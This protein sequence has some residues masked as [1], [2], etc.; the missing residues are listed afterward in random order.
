MFVLSIRRYEGQLLLSR[1]GGNFEA[2]QKLPKFCRLVA[3][4][5]TYLND[6]R[7]QNCPRTAFAKMWKMGV[8]MPC[9]KDHS[10]REAFRVELSALKEKE[11]FGYKRAEKGYL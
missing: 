7:A 1:V 6:V 3:L 5:K 4:Y 11:N 8:T 9:I 2:D 10:F